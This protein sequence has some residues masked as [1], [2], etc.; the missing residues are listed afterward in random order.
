MPRKSQDQVK[1]QNQVKSQK[2]SDNE[3]YIDFLNNFK[4]NVGKK[5]DV[6][7]SSMNEYFE[8]ILTQYRNDNDML[9]DKLDESNN[10][11]HNQEHKIIELETLI[12]THQNTILKLE[13]QIKQLEITLK[14]NEEKE[15]EEI[16]AGNEDD[17]DDA[18]NSEY[19]EEVDFCERVIN[20][21]TYFITDDDEQ[22]IYEKMDNDEVGE[23]L[24][25]IIDGKPEFD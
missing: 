8:Q 25:R 14:N 13:E 4:T 3:K 1:S 21:K 5:W 11:S 15:A 10:K 23:M 12:S 20:G 2:C 22:E 16:D 19:S 17:E 6:L 7:Y 18:D 9:K 24:G